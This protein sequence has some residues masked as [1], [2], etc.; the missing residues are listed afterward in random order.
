MLFERRRGRGG[1]ERS[2]QDSSPTSED[3]PD[4]TASNDAA[5]ASEDG[6][7][8]ADDVDVEIAEST[9]ASTSLNVGAQPFV[10]GRAKTASP[11][12]MIKL[13]K[14]KKH[15]HRSAFGSQSGNTQ[16]TEELDSDA[17]SRDIDAHGAMYIEGRNDRVLYS[18]H[19]YNGN[20]SKNKYSDS[21]HQNTAQPRS[22]QDSPKLSEHANNNTTDRAQ[23]TDGDSESKPE[24][25]NQ[26]TPDGAS[27]DVP[28]RTDGPAERKKAA[29]A[30]ME[31]EVRKQR[32]KAL[33]NFVDKKPVDVTNIEN[34][35]GLN[36]LLICIG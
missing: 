33:H 30:E 10:P 32:H 21:L 23:R 11:P 34:L 9:L 12:N 29:A 17:A 2:S 15:Q 36:T 19:R 1:K 7:S 25:S 20:S 26:G 24:L 27:K 14:V 22:S 13:G 16:P 4:V 28:K 3:A 35:R 8:S 18:G 5:T 6:D 31:R